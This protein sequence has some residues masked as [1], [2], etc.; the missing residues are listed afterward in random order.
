M[1]R[2]KERW[3]Y[4]P[5]IATFP[6]SLRVSDITAFVLQHTTFPTIIIVHGVLLFCSQLCTCEVVN[7]FMFDVAKT[8]I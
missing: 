5:S 4:K 6:L 7:M 1:Y 3:P 8:I 2:S